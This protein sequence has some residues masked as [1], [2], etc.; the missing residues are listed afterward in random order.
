MSSVID[1]NTKTSTPDER[2]EE[3]KSTKTSYNIA[4]KLLVSNSA[5]GS[6]IGRAGS[7]ITELQSQ[8]SSRIKLSQSGDCFPGT[9]ERVCLIKGDVENVK[10]GITLILKR[11]I[12]TR[13]GDQDDENIVQGEKE[14]PSEKCIEG[15]N[16]EEITAETSTTSGSPAPTLTYIIK[17]L[18]PSSACGLLIGRSGRHIKSIS[19]SSQT[20]IQLAQKE[21]VSSLATSER[22]LSIFGGKENILQCIGLII[23][24]IEQEMKEIGGNEENSVWRYVNMTTG[25]SRRMG[26]AAN[27]VKGIPYTDRMIPT[28]HIPIEKHYGSPIHHHMSHPHQGSGLLHPSPMHLD[29]SHLLSSP[30]GNPGVFIPPPLQQNALRPPVATINYAN[31]PPSAASAASISHAAAQ[32]QYLGPNGPVYKI[33]EESYSAT[34]AAQDGGGHYTVTLAVPDPM[35]GAIIGHNGSTLMQLQL[36]SQTRIQISQRNEYVPGTNHRILKIT[37]ISQENCDAAHFWIGQR[38]SLAHM[39]IDS[40]GYGMKSNSKH[41]AKPKGNPET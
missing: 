14:G 2:D 34:G 24:S 4:L 23:D 9:N 40:G 16:E 5:A 6:I 13:D 30:G 27:V 8:S 3:N 7:T 1:P 38:I 39:G 17:I 19:N 25:Y 33:E 41:G 31:L 26:P 22:I 35:I 18:I 20:R 12:F 29:G 37:G 32:V 28:A 21:E 36:C 15:K 11:F 10:T